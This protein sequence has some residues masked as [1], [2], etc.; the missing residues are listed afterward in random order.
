[1]SA[2]S[3]KAAESLAESLSKQVKH[4]SRTETRRLIHQF[5]GRCG[6]QPGR[7]AGSGLDRG[8][9]RNML[10]RTFGLT[11]DIIMDRVFSVFDRDNDGYIGVREWIAGLAVFLRGSLDEKIKFCFEVY[12]LNGDGAISREE[13]FH[14][15]KWSLSRQPA[16]EDPEEGIKDLVEIVLKKMDHG[17]NSKVSYADFEKTVREENLLLEAFGTCLPNAKSIQA[18]EQQTFQDLPQL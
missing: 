13:M 16:E 10:H 8:Q 12:D 1:M 7:R 6:Q 3:R 14:M 2:A 11:H 15:L 17:H 9:F 4:F 5:E 18:F